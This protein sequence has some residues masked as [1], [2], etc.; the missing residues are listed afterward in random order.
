MKVE[1]VRF[2]TVEV[3]DDR[4]VHFVRPIVGFDELGDYGLIDDP[5]TAPV[6]WLQSLD[7]PDVL[8]PLVD[9]ALVA[10]G[11]TVDLDDEAV[12]ALGVERAEEARLLGILTLSQEPS[13]VSVNLRAPIVLNARRATALQLVLQDADLPVR[14]PVRADEG[15]SRSNK[16][17]ARAGS[18]TPQG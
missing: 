13:A 12:A 7:A 1:S 8:F 15:A 6:L 17:V 11:Y 14:H 18:H 4:V 16:E 10:G 3:A 2:G 5:T 9:L